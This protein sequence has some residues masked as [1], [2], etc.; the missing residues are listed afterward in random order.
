MPSAELFCHP[1][2]RKRTP[3]LLRLQQPDE[4]K[5]GTRVRVLDGALARDPEDTT[6][7]AIV[8]LS[9]LSEAYR[10]E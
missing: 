4:F 1:P 5:T 8:T 9:A 10:V 2:T 3:A 6:A 7:P